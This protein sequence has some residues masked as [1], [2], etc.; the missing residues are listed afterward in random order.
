[1]LGEARL[2]HIIMF[3]NI[4]IK[5]YVIQDQKKGAPLLSVFF[6]SN[7]SYWKP[8]IFISFFPPSPTP[9]PPYPLLKYFHQP[10][11]FLHGEKQLGT[12][13]TSRQ[14]SYFLSIGTKPF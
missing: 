3:Y 14:S 1:M 7:K 4:K 2:H 12:M 6:Q 9:P 10:F 13:I 5:N 8:E 11:T